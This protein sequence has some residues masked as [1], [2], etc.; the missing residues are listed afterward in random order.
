VGNARRGKRKRLN[1]KEMKEKD[2]KWRKWRV[3]EE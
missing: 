1:A 3:G 2:Q